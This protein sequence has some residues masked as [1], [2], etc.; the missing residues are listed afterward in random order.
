MLL[1]DEVDIFFGEHFYGASYC[2]KASIKDT[3]LLNLIEYLWSIKDD[4]NQLGRAVLRSPQYLACEAR[5]PEWKDLL[6]FNLKHMVSDLR[7]MGEYIKGKHYVLQKGQVMSLRYY[8]HI[9]PFD[10][11]LIVTSRLS[12]IGYV[13]DGSDGASFNIV[14]GYKTMWAYFREFTAGLV[15]RQSLEK[16]ITLVINCGA[17]SYAE[18]PKMY[19]LIMGVTGTLETMTPPQWDLFKEDYDVRKFAYIPSMYSANQRI[20]HGDSPEDC[21]I[22]SKSTFHMVLAD[23]IVERLALKKHKSN[24]NSLVGRAVLVFFDT[25]AE[26]DAFKDNQNVKSKGLIFNEI[27]EETSADEKK[28][29]ILSAVEKCQ[30]TIMTKIFGRGTDFKCQSEGVL[31]EGGIHV[32]Q[33]FFSEDLC[34]EYQIMGRSARMGDPGSY[35]MVL[36]DRCLEMFFGEQTGEAI[37]HMQSTGKFHSYIDGRRRCY[38]E[39]KFPEKTRHVVEDLRRKH[40]KAAD[41]IGSLI[42]DD[43]PAVRAFLLDENLVEG[44]LGGVGVGRTIVL[45]DATGSMRDLLEKCKSTVSTMFEDGHKLLREDKTASPFEMQLAVYRNYSSR[46]GCL[47][48]GNAVDSILQAS[49]WNSKPE[50]LQAFMK[51]VRPAGGQGNEAIEMGFWHVNQEIERAKQAM[52]DPVTQVI[53][54]ADMPPN[55]RAEV[56]SKRNGR[57]EQYW[58]RMCPPTYWEDELTRMKGPDGVAI[59]VHS[60]YVHSAAKSAFE[61]IARRTGGRTG[62]LDIAG[63]EGAAMLQNLVMSEV[64]RVAGGDELVRKY[65]AMKGFI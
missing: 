43:M 3:T 1:I 6:L 63:T 2:V 38:F 27:T 26:L 23:Q 51:T 7:S 15:D 57:G 14:D 9:F 55:S 22:E 11:P 5:F 46:A 65:R 24:P 41:F 58:S 53:L 48:D 13:V 62:P 42:S 4:K 8:L 54:I 16:F 36:Q 40:Q 45:M 25:K 61:D 17:F 52:T 20:F 28:R 56:I 44:D 47:E 37:K 29:L 19:S 21:R 30:V 64:L 35:S 50:G 12:Q 39:A 59:P 18:I 31:K 49:P 60:F 33:T 32:I 10:P 34:E